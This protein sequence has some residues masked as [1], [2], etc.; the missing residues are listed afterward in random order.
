MNL[1]LNLCMPDS[2]DQKLV[3]KSGAAVNNS[4]T[5]ANESNIAD[6]KQFLY[7]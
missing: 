4:T 3:G 6:Q 7:Q 1:N 2:N 5:S